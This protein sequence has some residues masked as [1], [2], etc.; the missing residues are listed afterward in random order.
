MKAYL[1][2]RLASLLPILLGLSV[3]TFGLMGL[4][5]GDPAEILARQGRDV[6]PTP[7]QIEATRRA[8]GLDQPLPVQYARWLGRVLRGDLG[9]SARTGEPVWAELRDRFPATLE[10]ALAGLAVGI[11]IALPVGTLAAVWRGTIVDALSRFLALLGA[12]VPSFWL[13]AMLILLFAVRLRWLPAMGRGS[14]TQ[15]A[16][17]A[18]ALGVSASAV[19][20]RLTRASLLETLRQDYVRTAR[21]KGLRESAVVLRHALKPAMLP[22]ITIVGLQF[23]NLLGGAL[24]IETIFAWPGLG[25]FMMTSIRARDLPVI[26]GFTLMMGLVFVGANLA[27]DVAYRWLDPRIADRA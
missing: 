7:A 19:L 21:A 11:L 23:G 15:I 18:M 3:I 9:T 16:L 27:V 24:V 10:L 5:P 13:G 22:V 14:L 2:W 20:M 8:L 25:Q 1:L 17:P 26:Q 6:D 4:V 12:A